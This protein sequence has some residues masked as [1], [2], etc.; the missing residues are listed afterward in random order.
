MVARGNLAE[1]ACGDGTCDGCGAKMS[2]GVP[3]GASRAIPGCADAADG[4]EDGPSRKKRRTKVRERRE[5]GLKQ[6]QENQAAGAP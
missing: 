5:G 4:D 2:G 6:E 1:E 3:P